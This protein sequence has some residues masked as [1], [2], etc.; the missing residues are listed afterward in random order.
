MR[1]VNSSERTSSIFRIYQ[2]LQTL[3]KEFFKNCQ[4]ADQFDEERTFF[5]LKQCLLES[6][7]RIK[8]ASHQSTR[9][10]LFLV[11]TENIREIRLI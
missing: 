1:N 8:K 6:V 5:C 3:H 10:V 4:I 7:R 2:L 9:V 11:R